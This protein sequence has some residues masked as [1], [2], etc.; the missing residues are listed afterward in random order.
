ME[1]H[2]NMA[3]PGDDDLPIVPEMVQLNLKTGGRLLFDPTQLFGVAEAEDKTAILITATGGA[4]PLAQS[5]K[6]VVQ[7]LKELAE[8]DDGD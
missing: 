6:D 4:F 3:Q 8:A 5:F 1:V 2:L 7:F